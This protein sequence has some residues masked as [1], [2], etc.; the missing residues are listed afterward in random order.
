MQGTHIQSLVQEDPT[1][2]GANKPVRHITDSVLKSPGTATTEAWTP[3]ARALQQE[4][5]LQWEAPAR[6]QSVDPHSLQLEK[7]PHGNKD[8]AEPEVNQ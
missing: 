3:R 2:H 4:K 8:P 5:Q 7:S 6:Q 1:C